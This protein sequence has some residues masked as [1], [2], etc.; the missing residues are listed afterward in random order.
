MTK[1]AFAGTIQSI[2][3]VDVIDSETNYYISVAEDSDWEI[4]SDND[5]FP[6]CCKLQQGEKYLFY[7]ELTCFT[8]N[9]IVHEVATEPSHLKSDSI[10]GKSNNVGTLVNLCGKIEHVEFVT[11]KRGNQIAYAIFENMPEVKVMFLQ[12]EELKKA[13]DSNAEISIVGELDIT[14]P[15]FTVE[16]ATLVK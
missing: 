12:T 5:T 15:V 11:T 10:I 9:I 13:C 7:G 2:D 1:A 14:K 16:Q 6:E 3:A 8:P 4:N